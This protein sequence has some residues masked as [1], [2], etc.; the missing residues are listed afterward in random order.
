[1]DATAAAVA[2]AEDPD[3]EG[4]IALALVAI[5]EIAANGWD[6]NIGRYVRGEAAAEIDMEEAVAAYLEAREGG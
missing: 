5:D 2:A 6:M 4:G 3:R 1:M